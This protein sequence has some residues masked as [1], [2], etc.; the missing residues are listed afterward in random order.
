M[1]LSS[2][3]GNMADLSKK[4]SCGQGLLELP[5]AIVD[6]IVSCLGGDGKIIVMQVCRKAAFLVAML[7]PETKLKLNMDAKLAGIRKVSSLQPYAQLMHRL[8]IV[9]M[10]C[11]R[12]LASFCTA[13]A[14][15]VAIPTNPS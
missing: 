5:D 3:G 7:T 11:M 2:G 8:T 14:R 10:C 9:D 12:Q 13:G 4:S 15:L 1:G 6:L